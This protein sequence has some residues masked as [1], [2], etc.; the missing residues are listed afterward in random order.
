MSD[1]VKIATDIE[2]NYR[3]FDA[4]IILHGTDTMAYTAS[5]LSFM[6]E[7]LGKTVVLTGSQVPLAEVRNDAV[8]NLLGALTIAAHF[9]I[10]EVGLFFGHKLLRGNRSSKINAVDFNAFDSPNLRPLVTVGI[11]I[12]VSWADVLRPTTIATFRAHKVL[13]PS[14]ATLRLFPGITDATVRA[15]LAPP[16]AGVVLETY[17]AG[18]A[19]NN[20][21]DLLQALK[22]AT[23]RGVVIVNCTQCKRGLVTDLYATG[24]ALLECGV[25]PGA[26]MTAECALTKLSYLL[27][28]D[29]PPE[30]IRKLMRR[31]LRG[32][33]T[34]PARR[35]R[36]SH[37]LHTQGLVRA[38]LTLLRGGG[39][40]G[41][42]TPASAGIGGGNTGGTG[43]MAAASKPGNAAAS[44]VFSF[45]DAVGLDRALVPLILCQSARVGDVDALQAVTNEFETMINIGDYDGRTP[46]HVACSESQFAVVEFLLLHGAHVHVRDRF[47]HSPLFDAV[48]AAKIKGT[49]VGGGSGGGVGAES[50]NGA[51]SPEKRARQVVRLLKDAGAHFGE[52]EA[53]E[54]TNRV[55]SAA[56]VGDLETVQLFV[57]GGADIGRPWPLAKTML[58]S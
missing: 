39:G 20:R 22:E 56:A 35:Q 49:G 5:A 24:K 42:V 40:G 55:V 57:M 31:N 47:G 3:L 32:E 16:I 44:A 53:E 11:N 6:L 46:L 21:P 29:Y 37:Q 23:E 1:W 4:F 41:A 2:V 51:G 7:E 54:V 14:V 13:N 15:F 30:E 50:A 28:K 25:V 12:D 45:D 8:D 58:R 10:P 19:P 38:V 36:F 33:L 27:G 34:I 52:E 18:N 48:R 43:T 26:D 17:G 9:V